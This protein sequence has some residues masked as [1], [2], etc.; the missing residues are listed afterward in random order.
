MELVGSSIHATHGLP[1]ARSASA[2]A[3]RTALP[4]GRA[5]R[6]PP[7]SAV[8]NSVSTP[9]PNVR[10]TCSTPPVV[11]AAL[12]SWMYETTTRSATGPVAMRGERARGVAA[13]AGLPTAND[14][15]ALQSTPARLAR[16]SASRA[17]L[18]YVNATCAASLA[19]R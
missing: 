4:V 18:S 7:G 10:S 19:V 15:D 5:L 6:A 1:S 9:L 12:A 16:P 14:G 8:G 3:W 17:P 13:S 11:V 2:V